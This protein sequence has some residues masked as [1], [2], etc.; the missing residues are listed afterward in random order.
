MFNDC[1]IILNVFCYVTLFVL[2]VTTNCWRNIC[3]RKY[4]WETSINLAFTSLWIVACIYNIHNP[5]ICKLVWDIKPPRYIFIDQELTSCCAN[6]RRSWSHNLGPWKSASRCCHKIIAEQQQQIT[7]RCQCC[8]L[9][10]LGVRLCLVAPARLTAVGCEEWKA[11]KERLQSWG[12]E[13]F[14]AEQLAELW[15]CPSVERGMSFAPV[16]WFNELAN[17]S[18]HA[19]C[20]TCGTAPFF[21]P[22]LLH[23]MAATKTWLTSACFP[24]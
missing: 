19:T 8:L 14:G 21:S 4:S 2:Q 13:R 18:P 7:N 5:F 23:F 22:H 11:T 20:R 24:S 3:S 10:L 12:E 6:E 9:L 15:V 1:K 17:L 16:T